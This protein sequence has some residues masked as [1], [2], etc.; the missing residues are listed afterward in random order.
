VRSFPKTRRSG[1]IGDLVRRLGVAAAS[2]SALQTG[3]LRMVAWDIGVGLLALGESLATV[4][5]DAET[6]FVSVIV[7]PALRRV[8][9][10]C[11][12]FFTLSALRLAYVTRSPAEGSPSDVFINMTRYSTILIERS[13]FD[14]RSIASILSIS[15][16][17]SSQFETMSSALRFSC[18]SPSV[19]ASAAIPT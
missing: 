13:A 19:S 9:I 14:L 15:A 2:Y 16:N 6:M 11:S 4:S 7:R 3:F 17:I 5:N 10:A 8:E 12:T 18:P 1:R